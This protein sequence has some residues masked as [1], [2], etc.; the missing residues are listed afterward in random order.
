MAGLTMPDV[1][2]IGGWMK[3][4]FMPAAVPPAA[5]KIQIL[6]TLAEKARKEGLLALEGPIKE[7]QDPSCSAV[8]RWP[9][10]APTPRTSAP[11]SRPRSRPRRPRT[12]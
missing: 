3:Q 9:S 7:I 12:R 1:K 5:E 6:V 8:C 2:K 11:C 10:T 4:G